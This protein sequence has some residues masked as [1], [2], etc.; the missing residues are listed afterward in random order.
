[1]SYARFLMGS[2][3]PDPLQVPAMVGKPIARKKIVSTN[4]EGKN[5]CGK[6]I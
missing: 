3:L 5:G 1:M 6:S 2:G 4:L